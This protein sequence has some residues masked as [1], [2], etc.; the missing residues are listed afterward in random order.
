MFNR[1]PLWLRD[2]VFVPAASAASSGALR[3]LW[4]QQRQYAG[5][6]ACLHPARNV[7]HTKGP[8]WKIAI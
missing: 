2:P 4:L 8:I 7:K 3:S 6:V 1:F 5:W